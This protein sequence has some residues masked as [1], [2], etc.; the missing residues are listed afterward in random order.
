MWNEPTGLGES[1]ALSESDW[2]GYRKPRLDDGNDNCTCPATT[3]PLA[4]P[5]GMSTADLARYQ[6]R[7]A[8]YAR[9]RLHGTGQR[10]YAKAD[11]QGFEDMSFHRLVDE[12]VDELADIVNYASMLAI[13]LQRLRTEL[14]ERA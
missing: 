2:L 9:L 12:A 11:R 14:E 4:P 6:R 10:E 1:P 7:F 5:F 3:P 8:T 13:Q